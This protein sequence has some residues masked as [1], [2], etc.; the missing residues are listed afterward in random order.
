VGIDEHAWRIMR[1]EWHEEWSL[2][3]RFDCRIGMGTIE[4]AGNGLRES[5]GDRLVLGQYYLEER[6]RSWQDRRMLLTHDGCAK[7]VPCRDTLL[8]L[9]C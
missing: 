2:R 5:R 1:A 8:V 3:G 6:S 9:S 4:G 7:C